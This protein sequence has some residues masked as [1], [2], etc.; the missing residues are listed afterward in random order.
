ML[1]LKKRGNNNR[2]GKDEAARAS[3]G[4]YTQVRLT[5]ADSF[6]RGRYSM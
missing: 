5:K 3:N 6:S 2:R 4:P 1:N